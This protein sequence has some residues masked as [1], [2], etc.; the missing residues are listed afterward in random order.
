MFAGFKPWTNG[1]VL[2]EN[3][4]TLVWRLPRHNWYN[5]NPYGIEFT[6]VYQDETYV[7]MKVKKPQLPAPNSNDGN[8]S[9]KTTWGC[10]AYNDFQGTLADGVGATPKLVSGDIALDVISRRRCKR[11]YQES[12]SWVKFLQERMQITI[13][14]NA[15][16]WKLTEDGANGSKFKEF[17]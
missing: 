14:D 12:M 8:W 7:Y 3:P 11:L 13:Q 2:Y 1:D 15:N 16:G 9:T 17:S 5:E 4:V 10:K 6:P